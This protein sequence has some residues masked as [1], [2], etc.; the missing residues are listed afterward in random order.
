MRWEDYCGLSVCPNVTTSVFVRARRWQ[1]V[2]EQHVTNG[3]SK[4]KTRA[5][6]RTRENKRDRI[7]DATQVA[8]KTEVAAANAWRQP[9][10]G[11][12]TNTKMLVLYDSFQN[13]NIQHSRMIHWC[14]FQ[15]LT[16]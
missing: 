1:G 9:G 11:K 10:E 6:L 16:S 4:E 15:L 5:G 12:Y 8:L 3:S 14:C 7:E 2:R 13:C